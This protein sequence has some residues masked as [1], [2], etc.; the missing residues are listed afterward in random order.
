MV[1]LPEVKIQFDHSPAVFLDR[2]NAILWYSGLKYSGEFGKRLRSV[3][4]AAMRDD[5]RAALAAALR[6]SGVRPRRQVRE[7]HRGV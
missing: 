4:F 5:A 1:Y 6:V 2:L 7:N 3:Q